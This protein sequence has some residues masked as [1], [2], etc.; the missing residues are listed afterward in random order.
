MVPELVQVFAQVV[1]S[2]EE[3]T[4]VKNQV[5]LA[6]SHLIS[7]YGHQMQ[8]ILSSLPPAYANA[9]AAYANMER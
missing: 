3:N 2:V 9:L 7:L 1:A 4:E 8:P 5:G 6:F